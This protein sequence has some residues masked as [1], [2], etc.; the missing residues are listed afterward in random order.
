MCEKNLQK[1]QIY[2][3]IFKLRSQ[4][5]RIRRRGVLSESDKTTRRYDSYGL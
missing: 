5:N 4:S 2:A 3:V 1:A